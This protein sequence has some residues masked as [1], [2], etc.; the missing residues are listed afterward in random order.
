MTRE[1]RIEDIKAEISKL[2]NELSALKHDTLD[3]DK[4]I[5]PAVVGREKRIEERYTGLTGFLDV[6][7]ITLTPQYR[8]RRPG[9]WWTYPKHVKDLDEREY[10]AVCNCINDCMKVINKYAEELHPEG[11]AWGET[12]NGSFYKEKTD[13][14]E[15]EAESENK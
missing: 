12:Y 13:D 8:A 6:I 3:Y 1:Q 15:T 2:R 10:T 9:Y 5:Y 11:I 4:L 14:K 7:R